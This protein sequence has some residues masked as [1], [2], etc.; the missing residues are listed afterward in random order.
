MV[1]LPIAMINPVSWEVARGYQPINI[2]NLFMKYYF[3]DSCTVAIYKPILLLC[4]LIHH[5]RNIQKMMHPNF[6]S[7]FP[8]A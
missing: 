8:V 7:F 5:T 4:H 1:K 6:S 2:F 3:F